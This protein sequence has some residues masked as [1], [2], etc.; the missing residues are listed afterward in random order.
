MILSPINLSKT[1]SVLRIVSAYSY[2]LARSWIAL[3]D[4]YMYVMDALRLWAGATVKI[5]DAYNLRTKSL[6]DDRCCV[7]LHTR[8][9][10]VIHV[11]LPDMLLKQQQSTHQG[12]DII[13]QCNAMQC[14]SMRHRNAAMQQRTQRGDIHTNGHGGEK[15]S[16][17]SRLFA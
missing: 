12:R 8:A 16:F 11:R 7:V 13:L 15:P 1:Y 3:T 17:C 14:S 5:Q 9:T 10:D 4:A 6:L 2:N